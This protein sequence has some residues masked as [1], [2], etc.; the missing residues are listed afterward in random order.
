MLRQSCFMTPSLRRLFFALPKTAGCR[1]VFPFEQIYRATTL[2]RSRSPAQECA[3]CKQAVPPIFPCSGSNR[4]FASFALRRRRDLPVCLSER[5]G[6]VQGGCIQDFRRRASIETQGN[7]NSCFHGLVGHASVEVERLHTQRDVGSDTP[8]YSIPPG[9]LNRGRPG[10]NAEQGRQIVVNRSPFAARFMPDCLPLRSSISAHAIDGSGFLHAPSTAGRSVDT[11]VES[12]RWFLVQ[13]RLVHG[14]A[15]AALPLGKPLSMARLL[16][17][18]ERGEKISMVTSYD[19]NTARILDSALIDMQLVGDSLA[20]VILGL[21]STAL[22]DLDTMIL[23]S[24]HVKQACQRSVVV[25]DLPYGSY[26]TKEAAVESVV[27]VVKQTGITAVKLE[28]FC[29]EIVK[30]LRDHVSVICHLGVQPQTAQSMDSRGKNAQSALELLRQS[31]ALEAAGC[32]MIVLEKVCSEVAEVITAK[33]KIPTIGVGSGPSCDGQVLVFHDM[34]GLAPVGPKFKFVKQYANVHPDLQAAAN[35]FRRDVE[36]SVFPAIEHSFFMIPTERAKFYARIDEGL[37]V[38]LGGETRSA[39]TS[40]QERERDQGLPTPSIVRGWVAAGL[41]NKPGS[42]STNAARL[43]STPLRSSEDEQA[44]QPMLQGGSQA[45]PQETTGT[46]LKRVCVR[47]G[48]AMGQLVAWKLASVP[49]LEVVIATH[50]QELKEAVDRQGNLLLI[51][52]SPNGTQ[53]SDAYGDIEGRPVRVVV[54]REGLDKV[55]K[56]DEEPFDAVIICTQSWQTAEA[57]AF[58]LANLKPDG[59]VATVQNGLEAP[60][61]LRGIFGDALASRPN[62][63]SRSTQARAC[64]TPSEQCGVSSLPGDSGKEEPSGT[65]GSPSLVFAPTSYG[66]L[67][68]AAGHVLLTGEGQI[69]LGLSSPNERSTALS[70]LSALLRRAGTDVMEEDPFDVQV[71]I[72]QKASVSCYVNA[73]TAILGCRNGDVAH[74]LL[75]PLRRRIVEEVV[76]VARAQGIPVDFEATDQLV[77]DGIQKTARNFSS[78]LVDVQK[79]RQTEIDGINGEVVKMGRKVGVPT[80]ATETLMNLVKFITER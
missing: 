22:V 80:P 24:K 65:A 16:Q 3:F 7:S 77:V 20:N 35:Q 58:A 69:R 49:G 21:D 17:K 4:S 33:L 13:N 61:I 53:G 68:Q 27:R 57:G 38:Q 76:S 34:C 11:V 43:A 2:P 75:E 39:A 5:R 9:Y 79:R 44:C 15:G 36:K 56:L 59:I 55:E 52:K 71:A 12:G 47:G 29:P 1:G 60:R 14:Q 42:S 67:E 50:R 70:S 26:H 31:L 6:F 54:M 28:G 25:F 37:D 19:V 74:P 78:M 18:K 32:Q 23:F 64:S 8:K 63:P 41:V 73:V 48:G 62:A 46:D 66:A 51:E 30:A 10:R 72:W 40:S 45:L